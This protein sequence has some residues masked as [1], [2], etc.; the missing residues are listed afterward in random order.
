MDMSV[1]KNN[2]TTSG[3]SM[4]SLTFVRHQYFSG[5]ERGKMC[6]LKVARF[7]CGT[8]E[9]GC[10]TTNWSAVYQVK[11]QVSERPEIFLRSQEWQY[12]YSIFL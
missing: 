2:D 5:W 8:N 4:G 9:S 3:R 10:Y 6:L 11:K 7:L 1:L 12:Q